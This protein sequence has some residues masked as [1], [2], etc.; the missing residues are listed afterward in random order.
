MKFYDDYTN[1]LTFLEEI[2]S[3]GIETEQMITVC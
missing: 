3:K 2:K 1:R